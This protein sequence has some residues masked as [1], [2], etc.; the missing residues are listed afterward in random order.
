[1]ENIK[2]CEYCKKEID[3]KN[4]YGSGR[5]CN[6]VCQVKSV[7]KKGAQK[8]GEKAKKEAEKRK[9]K[10][11]CLECGKSIFTTNTN[12]KFCSRSCSNSFSNKHRVLSEETKKKQSEGVIKYYENNGYVRTSNP[13]NSKVG[14]TA[15]IQYFCRN[16]KIEIGKTKTGLCKE[17]LL[18]S[19]VG[20]EV[21]STNAKTAMDKLIKEGRHI[22]WTSRKVSS[23]PEQ[24]FEKVLTENNISFLRE[25]PIKKENYNYFLDFTI[26]KN[27]KVIDLEIDGKQH[28]YKER[29]ESDK[30]RDAYLSEKGF[31][32]YR[33]PWNEISSEQGKLEIKNKIEKFLEFY[34][35]I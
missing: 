31:I 14:K 33:I 1:M 18:H 17:C 29:K 7:N 2:L 15:K 4:I 10:I 11:V 13:K 34:N 5:F 30:I 28:E 24:F 3:L 8:A 20:K 27:G 23:F 25:K 21:M 32:V 12:R 35:S 9:I 6:R 19:K 16:C 26:E 22:G